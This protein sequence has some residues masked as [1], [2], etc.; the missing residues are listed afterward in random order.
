[1][2]R[3]KLKIHATSFD[4]VGIAGINTHIVSVRVGLGAEEGKEARL[5]VTRED[6]LNNLLV[7]IDNKGAATRQR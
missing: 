4:T 2:A 1:M 3:I 6:L 7:E 5:D